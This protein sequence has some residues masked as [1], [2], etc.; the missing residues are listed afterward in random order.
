[1]SAVE[2]EAAISDL[3]LESFDGRSFHSPSWQRLAT[4]T[5][6]SSGCTPATTTLRMCPVACFNATTSILQCAKPAAWAQYS[7]PCA[8]ARPPP[9]QRPG[10]PTE[11]GAVHYV[12]SSC[13][14]LHH[15]TGLV[16]LDIANRINFDD[17]VR[18]RQG[19]PC[20]S[21]PASRLPPDR[22]LRRNRS[23][24]LDG[25]RCGSFSAQSY[26]RAG[27]APWLPGCRS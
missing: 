2:I 1:M 11:H 12:V 15:E 5:P 27:H 14:S 22:A 19:S 4:R 26:R 16:V 21:C 8:P 17:A 9:K 20:A 18:L 7:R 13:L 25:W 24:G 6:P 10:K 23:C 3:A